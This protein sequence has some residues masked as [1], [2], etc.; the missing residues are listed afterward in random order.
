[1][2]DKE[3][4]RRSR[5]CEEWQEATSSTAEAPFGLRLLD[6]RHLFPHRPRWRVLA[7]LLH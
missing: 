4:K 7:L 1:M 5:S 2:L 3:T 6:D